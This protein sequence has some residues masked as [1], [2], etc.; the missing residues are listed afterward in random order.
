MTIQ[1]TIIGLRRIGASIGLAL[2]DHQELVKRVGHDRESSIARQ[3]EKMGAVDQISY[4]LPSSIRQA[5]LVILTEPLDQLLDS[6]KIIAPDLREGAVVMDTS[7]VKT[8]VIDQVTSLLPPERHYISLLPSTNPAYLT[9]SGSGIENAHADLFQKGLILIT[10]PS[11]ANAEAIKLAADLTKLLGA[12]PLFIDPAEA[13]G[14]SATVIQLP[15]I[16]AA[17]I[18]NATTEQPGWREARKLAGESYAT[19]TLPIL[20]LSEAEELGEALLLNRENA[21]RLIDYLSE[22][23]SDL[24]IAL[25]DQNEEALKERLQNART[26]REDWLKQRQAANWANAEPTPGVILNAGDVFNRFF[27]LRR[28]AKDRK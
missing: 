21:I 13:D 7:P 28:P 15:Q 25:A 27:G 14:L 6:L 10:H 24:R 23:L 18:L 20:D 8:G 4:N 22:A 19:A 5:D 3:A 12:T 26:A 1:I 9:E 11:G 2:K 16:T 17:A